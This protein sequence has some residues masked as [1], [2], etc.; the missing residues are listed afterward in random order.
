MSNSMGKLF[1]VTTFG[2]SHGPAIGAIVDG[3]PA[4]IKIVET[5]IQKQMDR[6][7]PG[8][9]SLTTQR[10]EADKVAILSGLQDGVTL[11]S[12]I[13]MTIANTDCRSADYEQ[14]LK[15]PRPSHADYT[16]L[17][18][19]GETAASGGGR[20]S[21]RETAA[22]VAAGTV[23]EEVLRQRHGVDIVAW[24]SAVGA[25]DCPDLSGTPP[26]RTEV[27]ATPVRCPDAAAADKM[28]AL[29]EKA[30]KSRDSIG[31]IV[32]CVCRN[33]PA[34]W[35]DPVFDKLNALLGRGLLSIP[36]ARGIEF[37]AGFGAARMAGSEHNDMFVKKGDR[38]GTVTNRSGGIQGGISNG[39]PIVM[40]IAFKPTASIA[41]TQAT[42]D[43]DG[44][45]V[46]FEMKGR[47]DPCIL[48]R[49]VPVVEAMTA[50]V[51]ADVGLC[52]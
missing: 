23:A 1:V 48:P 11:G 31:G 32:T 42:V 25:V 24:V 17:V 29:I 12:P 43:Y 26:T 39:E 49:A 13:A 46:T 40:R 14:V 4:G 51:L 6:R 5:V 19:Y 38:L 7:R 10:A 35:G 27:D 20:A 18:K 16:Y 22:R 34:G 28:T 47:H 44:R 45:L 8:Q 21:A 2:E 30:V 33:V 3:C 52:A 9:S 37:G 50:I 15:I 36:A 41:A